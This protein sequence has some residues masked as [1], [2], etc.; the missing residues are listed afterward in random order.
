M[1]GLSRSVFETR[2]PSSNHILRISRESASHSRCLCVRTPFP[3]PSTFIPFERNTALRSVRA[4][5][6][7]APNRMSVHDR[8]AST[9]HTMARWSRA[10]AD[11]RPSPRT[12]FAAFVY[13][14]KTARAPGC[15]CPSVEVIASRKGSREI[16]ALKFPLV[17]RT[18][19][20][21]VE[22]SSNLRQ[23]SNGIREAQVL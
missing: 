12:T 18:H 19:S 5:K 11:G 1:P 9:P 4:R 3:V 10:S 22:T 23:V 15:P 13:L 14:E 17:P 8:A 20:T 2:S 21:R 16:T 6:H 7:R